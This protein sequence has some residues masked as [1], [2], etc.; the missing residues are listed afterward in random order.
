[1]Q[2]ARGSIFFGQ[3]PMRIPKY[4]AQNNI[5]TKPGFEK[6]PYL[7]KATNKG[8]KV[9]SKSWHVHYLK[10]NKDSLKVAVS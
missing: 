3:N 7:V 6:I 4:S 9:R 5:V 1:M 8:T 10:G 2:T